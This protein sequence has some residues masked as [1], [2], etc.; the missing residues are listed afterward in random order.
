MLHLL[1]RSLAPRIRSLLPLGALA[2]FALLSAAYFRAEFDINVEEDGSGSIT[3]VI[4]LSEE[5]LDALEGF[6]E[7]DASADPFSIQTE[8][9]PAG[10]RVEEYERDGFRGS[11]VTIDF[12]AG[13]DVLESL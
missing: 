9:L 10:A 5:T 11:Q 4:A 12:G 6:G 1:D 13:D 8:D 2:L 7:D 3:M